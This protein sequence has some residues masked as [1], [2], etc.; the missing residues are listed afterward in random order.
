VQWEEREREEKVEVGGRRVAR[1]TERREMGGYKRKRERSRENGTAALS[2][3]EVMARYAQAIA[4]PYL[5]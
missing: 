5:R 4:E 1:G 3:V 2:A